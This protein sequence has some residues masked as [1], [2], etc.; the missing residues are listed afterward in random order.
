VTSSP[1]N[2]LP[3]LPAKGEP[4]EEILAGLARLRGKDVP[5]EGGRLFSYVFEHGDADLSRLQHQAFTAFSAINMLDPTAFPSVAAMENEVIGRLLDIFG[6][7]PDAAGT[8]TSGGTESCLLAV[9]SAAVLASEAGREGGDNKAG[10][11]LVL[12]ESAHPAF[13]KAAEWLGIDVVRV[14]VSANTLTPSAADLLAAVTERTV[15]VV[16]S[17]VSYPHGVLDPVAEVAAGCLERGVPLHVDGC[18]GGLV[19]AGRRALGELVPPFDLSVPG[20]SSLSVDLHK[21]GYAM[22]PAS[23]VLFADRERRRA[24]WFSY[25]AWAGYPIVNSTIQS[26]KSAGPLAATWATLRAL[27]SSGY[28][29]AFERQLRATRTIAAAIEATPGIRLLGSPAASLLAFASDEASVDVGAVNDAMRARGWHLQAQLAF[30][31]APPSV[32]LTVDAGAEATADA[33]AADLAEAVAEVRA[34]PPEPIDPGFAQ[35][36]SSLD[37]TAVTPENLAGLLA[38]AGLADG[39]LVVNARVNAMIQ[40]LAPDVRAAVITLVADGVFTAVRGV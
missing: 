40:L 38:A 33:L 18:I 15:L 26:T 31:A 8:F 27:G 4:H 14:P 9:R 25:G 34:D 37:V 30:G 2:K 23:A 10:G 22:K 28:L 21:Y 19:L 12:A 13:A 20:V 24:S 1:A 35:L 17:A 6:A 5:H 32:H 11:E 39:K 36:L 29:S 16:V 7:G 3:G